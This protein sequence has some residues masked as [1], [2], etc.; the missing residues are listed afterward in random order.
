MFGLRSDVISLR[1]DLTGYFGPKDFLLNSGFETINIVC[2]Y[3]QKDISYFK[4][5]A[6]DLGKEIKEE[7]LLNESYLR[8]DPNWFED[9]NLPAGSVRETAWRAMSI[10]GLVDV[11]GGKRRISKLY[12]AIAF[13]LLYAMEAKGEG[14]KDIVGDDPQKVT[15]LVLAY[16][17][18]CGEWRVTDNARQ[19]AEIKSFEKR[20]IGNFEKQI[21][22]FHLRKPLHG[23]SIKAVY[24]ELAQ[25][26]GSKGE[27]VKAG[28]KLY[29]EN[30]LWAEIL[31]IGLTE[32]D[33]VRREELLEQLFSSEKHIQ[34]L[35]QAQFKDSFVFSLFGFWL[36]REHLPQL[37]EEDRRRLIEPEEAP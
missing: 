11:F 2:D 10:L 7:V 29:Y 14:F 16:G 26:I 24:I 31:S 27:P 19:N 8:H 25:A 37:S 30:M 35:K 6:L 3:E 33:S 36:I 17:E 5:L 23:R 13:F 34:A 21:S 22:M 12:T 28:R 9:W 32:G 1:F 15:R 20:A 18:L 4:D